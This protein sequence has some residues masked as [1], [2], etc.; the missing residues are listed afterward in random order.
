VS[1]SSAADANTPQSLGRRHSS[2]RSA[3]HSARCEP[4]HI[5]GVAGGYEGRRLVF[6]EMTLQSQDTRENLY[7]RHQ[8][9]EHD[10]KVDTKR[11]S[12]TPTCPSR[13]D[14]GASAL[15]IVLH[16]GTGTD[17][18]GVINSFAGHLNGTRRQ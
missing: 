9:P 10:L 4:A 12:C 15:L 2:C 3:I 17:P 13:T 14:R 6:F 18:A 8:M 7:H 5:S 11:G 16:G 1:F